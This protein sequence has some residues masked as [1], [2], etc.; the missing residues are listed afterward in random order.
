MGKPLPEAAGP[1]QARSEVPDWDSVAPDG[2]Q[3][4]IF[5]DVLLAPAAPDVLNTRGRKEIEI[6]R[7]ASPSVVLVATDRGLGSGS[8]LGGGQVLT[9]WHVVRSFNAVGVIF[10]PAQEGGPIDED[11][12]IRAEVVY[13]DQVRDLA[14][15]KVA[16]VPK[17]RPMQ[18]GSEAEIEIGADVHAIGHPI[19]KAWTY[20]K[21]VISQF[22]K[23][24]EWKSGNVGVAHRASVIQTQTP[25]NPGNSGGPLIGDSGKMIGVNSFGVATAQ[26]LNYAVSVSEVQAFLQA[27]GRAATASKDKKCKVAKVYEGRNRSGDGRIVQF[28]TNCDGGV[29]FTLV[30]LDDQSK[31]ISALIDSNHDGKVDI[32][33]EDTNR[34]GKWDV[35]FHDVD[36]DGRIDLVGYHPDGKLQASRFEKFER[37]AAKR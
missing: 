9:N 6:Y 18:L 24:Y 16:E 12:V 31:P 20:T 22:R 7:N 34:D 26:G 27:A 21:G 8:Y 4:K 37:Y 25:I 33:V 30:F 11:S 23:D 1:P 5:K 36:H 10:K 32:I 2:L 35:S 29:D 28:D 3:G 17:A 14:L 19:G 15:L 13:T